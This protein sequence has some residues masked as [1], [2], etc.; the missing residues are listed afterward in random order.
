MTI[1]NLRRELLEQMCLVADRGHE[2]YAVFE[3]LPNK[4]E[5]A[6]SL[7]GVENPVFFHPGLGDKLIFRLI[8]DT[9]MASIYSED[10]T[11]TNK[12]TIAL[13]IM[14]NYYFPDYSEFDRQQLAE[15]KGEIA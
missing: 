11:R 9:V 14:G 15:A 7:F 13:N 10:R 8:L 6:E 2:V 3:P 5:I 12:A 4:K 1:E